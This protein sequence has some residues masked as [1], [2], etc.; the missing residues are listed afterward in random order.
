MS[1]PIVSAGSRPSR[2][3]PDP[4]SFRA[5]PLLADHRARLHR[6]PRRGVGPSGHGDDRVFERLTLEAFQ[7]GLSWITILRKREN[8]RAAFAGFSIPAVAAFG[9]ADVS[10]CS[11]TPASSA[12]APRSRPRS[13]TR[14]PPSTSSAVRAGLA[15]RR[16]RRSPA[17]KTLADVP[18]QTPASK[19]LAKELKTHGFRFVGPTTAYALMQAIGLVNDHLADCWTRDGPSVSALRPGPTAARACVRCA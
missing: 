15:L 1:E 2:S 4:A 19:A 10:G 9:Q 12:T 14:G 13:P 7:S 8:F 18:A 3:R 6:L 17:P 11:A 16:T 5:G